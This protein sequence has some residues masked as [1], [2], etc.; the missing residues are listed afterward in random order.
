M[1]Q[2]GTELGQGI[3]TFV[4]SGLDL[5]SHTEGIEPPPMDVV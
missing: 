1:P 5:K 3:D 4:A 2:E